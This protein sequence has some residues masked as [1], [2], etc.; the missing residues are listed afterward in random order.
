VCGFDS[1]FG[2]SASGAAPSGY[3]TELL[4]Q[5][6]K[7]GQVFLISNFHHV[8]YVVCFL[9]GNSP[10]SEFYMPTFRNTLFHLHMQVGVYLFTYLPM[11]MEQAVFRNV[12]I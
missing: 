9:L 5:K 7:N 8:L 2:R 10:A 6:I 11:K 12:G 4:I 1:P 3:G